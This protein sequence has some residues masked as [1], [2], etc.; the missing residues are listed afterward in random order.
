[1]TRKK[2]V[3]KRVTLVVTTSFN[4]LYKGQT[5]T[6]DYDDT[7]SGWERAGLVKVVGDAPSTAG[8][9]RVVADDPGSVPERAGSEGAAGG[10][11]GEDPVS[12]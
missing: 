10:E 6:V 12:G 4:G 8:P 5:A 3:A 1:M 11:P 9:G 7:V 2:T